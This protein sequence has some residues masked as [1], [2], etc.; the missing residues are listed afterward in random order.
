[1]QRRRAVLL[2]LLA[3]C[4]FDFNEL[5]D[6]GLGDTGG[7]A[8]DSAGPALNRVFTTSAAFTGQLVFGSLTGVAAGD[9]IC[10]DE[11]AA[12]GMTGTF[13]AWL[14]DDTRNATDLLA[15]SSGW[16]RVDG[17][18]FAQ[19]VADFTAQNNFTAFSVDVH[20]QFIPDTAMIRLGGSPSGVTQ[21]TDT[22]TNFTDDTM[23]VSTAQWA[24]SVGDAGT[25]F[26]AC[27]QQLAL[28]CVEYGRQASVPF[29]GTGRYAFGVRS[30][31]PTS[32]ADADAI[33]TANATQLGLPGSYVAALATST[34]SIEERA[35]T[36][37]GP[38]QRPGHIPVSSGPL[39]GTLLA[40]IGQDTGLQYMVW[41]GA[42][43]L[44]ARQPAAAQSCSDWTMSSGGGNSGDLA[45]DDES[46]WLDL[47][48][49]SCATSPIGL[50]CLQH[51]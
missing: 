8:G 6:A 16:V 40:P 35:G 2:M 9:A 33:C 51:A 49:S 27:N 28:G 41:T 50:L 29:E 17:V 11:A 37:D 32:L 21:G 46:D 22:C 39:G 36:L 13:A 24:H 42:T 38:W 5:T 47:F 10:T 15:G 44:T 20:G 48:V 18:P 14:S 25:S 7:N 12:A 26:G 30:W 19:T 3:G 31:T 45:Y 43:S 23:G 34:Q 1:M 4:R